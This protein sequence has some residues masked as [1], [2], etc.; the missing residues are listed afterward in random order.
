[1]G[2]TVRPSPECTPAQTSRGIFYQSPWQHISSL[3]SPGGGKKRFIRFRY[4]DI[5]ST[6]VFP[7]QNWFFGWLLSCE[8]TVFSGLCSI[9]RTVIKK[10][11]QYQRP[12]QSASEELENLLLKFL[13]QVNIFLFTVVVCLPLEL[14]VFIFYFQLY[15]VFAGILHPKTKPQPT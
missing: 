4:H 14:F 12:V 6:H 11:Y 9:A 15:C 1:M 13:L 2:G 5:F 10:W 3:P 8:T 7:S